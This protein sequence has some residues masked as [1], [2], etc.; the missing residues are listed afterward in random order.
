MESRNSTRFDRNFIVKLLKKA[1]A[2]SGCS[3]LVQE[4]AFTQLLCAGKKL[5]KYFWSRKFVLFVGFNHCLDS[6]A[7]DWYDKC[8]QIKPYL[9]K[10]NECNRKFNK[11]RDVW[12]SVMLEYPNI[13]IDLT[14]EAVVQHVFRLWNERFNWFL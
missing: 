8:T 11:K 1:E 5:S 3:S 12:R 2:Y 14:N 4:P 10:W 6:T 9:C 7:F 13:E